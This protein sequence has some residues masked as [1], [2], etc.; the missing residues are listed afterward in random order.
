M[1]PLE[2]HAGANPRCH[3]IFGFTQA[4]GRLLYQK[5]DALISGISALRRERERDSREF[6]CPFHHVKIH[7]E[8]MS[9]MNQGGLTR[10]WAF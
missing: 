5:S 1:C 8:K 9:V 4:F 6:P 2:I 10:P 3:G 7:Q